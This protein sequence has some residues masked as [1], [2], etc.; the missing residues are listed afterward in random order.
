MNV[1]LSIKNLEGKNPL[2]SPRTKPIA[3]VS[4]RPIECKVYILSQHLQ[5]SRAD[6]TTPRKSRSVSSLPILTLCPL[7]DDWPN[8]GVASAARA[9]CDVSRGGSSRD[10]KLDQAPQIRWRVNGLPDNPSGDGH[11]HQGFPD[12]ILGVDVR[13]SFLAVVHVVLSMIL[14]M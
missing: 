8:R 5:G 11:Y 6:Q 4:R 7:S 10:A 3:S 12:V 2:S 14:N 9:N 1:I 13:L